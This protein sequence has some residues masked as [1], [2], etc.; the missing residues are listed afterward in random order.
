MTLK[1]EKRSPKRDEHDVI[2][3]MD[4]GESSEFRVLSSEWVSEWVSEWASERSF[5]WASEWASDWASEWMSEY[6]NNAL[7][8]DP[9]TLSVMK[10]N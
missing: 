10:V 4:G 2:M 9:V 5:E 6:I 1:N 3:N 7:F 8:N